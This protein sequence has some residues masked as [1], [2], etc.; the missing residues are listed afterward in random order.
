[1]LHALLDTTEKQIFQFLSYCYE[2]NKPKYT[3]KELSDVFNRR[4]NKMQSI[5]Q[6]VE[7]FCAR[8][9][10]FTLIYD[11]Q[12]KEVLIAFSP[13]FLLSQAYNV[14]LQGTVGFILL[15]ALFHG[16]YHSLEQLSLKTFS[17]LRTVQRKLQELNHILANYHL[18]YSLKKG[19]P[20]TGEEYA[21]RYF[22]HLTYWQIFDEKHSQVVASIKDKE[23]IMALFETHASYMRKIDIDK[24]L[25]LFAISLQRIHQK[26]P[27]T[28][29]P[30]EVSTF[31]HPLIE[32]NQFFEVFLKPLFNG[33]HLSLSEISEPECSFLYFMFGVMNTYLEED[34]CEAE[35]SWLTQPKYQPEVLLVEQ[36]AQC[37]RLRF[38]DAEKNYLLVNF[39]MI[40]SASNLFGTRQK[41]DSFGKP[42]DKQELQAAFP[43][44]YPTVKR[45]F[46]EATVSLPDLRALLQKNDRLIFQYCMLLR[47]IFI[48]YEQPVTFSI[49]SKY[50]KTQE[51]WMKNR[52]LNATHRA[53]AHLSLTQKPDLVISDYPIHQEFSEEEQ[54]YIFYWNGQPSA[55]EWKQLKQT[56]KQIR[57]AKNK[58]AFEKLVFAQSI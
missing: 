53:M 57:S 3:I 36:L 41:S 31:E 26:H 16:D 25:N 23:S 35:L 24:F 27:I 22:Y 20:L 49:H 50:G 8:Y 48:K 15:D 52:L 2:T 46:E 43:V 32:R 28:F 29:L 19:D 10:Q 42:T 44:L 58:A 51:L 33:N 40:H 7:W 18:S 34:L 5:V 38:T 55:K 17:S 56:I 54:P 47:V 12:E 4:T 37:F 1:M 11:E 13:R 6:Q 14:L 21:I 39:V 9:P 30:E 45:F